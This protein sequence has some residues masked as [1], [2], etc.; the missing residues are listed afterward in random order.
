MEVLNVVDEKL[1]ESIYRAITQSSIIRG[2]VNR[3]L[4]FSRLA[5]EKLRT[6]IEDLEEMRSWL[7]AGKDAPPTVIPTLDWLLSLEN[8][9]RGIG[10]DNLLRDFGEF[11][12]SVIRH[13]IIPRL[14][15][16]AQQVFFE[17]LPEERQDGEE[18][19]SLQQ[20]QKKLDELLRR[21]R[22]QQR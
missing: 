16:K 1:A 3:L 21:L 11:V 9:L 19:E 6:L 12:L 22:K 20:L 4:R 15:E 18:N 17:G 13:E 2:R 14:G 7:R 10:D 5:S 8:D